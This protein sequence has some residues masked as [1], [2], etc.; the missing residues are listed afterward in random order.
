MFERA[1]PEVYTPRDIAQA[2]GVSESHIRGLV[3]HGEIRSVAAFLAGNADPKWECYIPQKEAVRAVRAIRAGEAPG[4]AGLVGTSRFLSPALSHRRP[5][6]VPLLVS[7]SLHALVV[8]ALLVI[9]SLG[10]TTAEEKTDPI[11]KSDPVRLVFL[12]QPGP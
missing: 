7:T 8:A 4:G 12:M 1:L 5:T 9:G 2:A 3:Q 10:L 11:E 6:T